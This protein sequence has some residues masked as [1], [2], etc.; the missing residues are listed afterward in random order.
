VVENFDQLWVSLP[1][2]APGAFLASKLFHE[3]TQVAL[4]LD[5]EVKL[6][7][8]A[9]PTA[10]A[11]RDE[12]QRE[13]SGPTIGVAEHTL[14]VQFWKEYKGLTRIGPQAWV[15]LGELV[16]TTVVEVV[17]V[18]E[19]VVDS[20]GPS[21]SVVM[22]DVVGPSEQAARTNASIRTLQ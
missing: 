1:N 15:E 4:K 5:Q 14:V 17:V 16:N 2:W 7:K 8:V 19:E 3:L 9:G 20:N 21:A 13:S 22:L 18:V 10:N 12:P 11:A 6:S